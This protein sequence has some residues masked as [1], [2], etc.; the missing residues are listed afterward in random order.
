ML[1]LAL[2]LSHNHTLG[3]DAYAYGGV[4]LLLFTFYFC[5]STPRSQYSPNALAFF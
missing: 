3:I 2:N 5:I 1:D 4:F